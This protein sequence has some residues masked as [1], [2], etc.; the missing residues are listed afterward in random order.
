MGV[1][2]NPSG[3]VPL[4]AMVTSAES[5]ATAPLHQK[6]PTEMV[7]ASDQDASRANSTFFQVF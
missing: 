7:R 3:P 6:E 1:L 4:T 2:H 5:R